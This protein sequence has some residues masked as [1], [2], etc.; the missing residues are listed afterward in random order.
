[1]A[2]PTNICCFLFCICLPIW[3]NQTPNTLQIHADIL[4]Q[5]GEGEA[6]DSGSIC[7][8]GTP[9]DCEWSAWKSNERNS[10]SQLIIAYP[11]LPGKVR[12]PRGFG[13]RTRDSAGN[14]AMGQLPDN[15]Q[16]GASRP[17]KLSAVPTLRCRR[18]R[19]GDEFILIWA[20]AVSRVMTAQDAVSIGN[21]ALLDSVHVQ[22][23]KV[24]AQTETLA[25][26]TGQTQCKHGTHATCHAPR[27]LM[28]AETQD[29]Q[30][31]HATHIQLTYL[32]LQ[33]THK[34]KVV[35]PKSQ[36]TLTKAS[37]RR[38]HTDELNRSSRSTCN[39]MHSQQPM[40]MHVH[41]HI[42]NT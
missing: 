19:D 20:H 25:Q 18:I 37:T 11:E 7:S 26:G 34:T 40:I 5:G 31:K 12:L 24:A 10:P 3:D 6:T 32:L 42:R 28:Y 9:R 8:P 30:C 36:H 22:A 35:L 23:S 13:F 38:V 1:M 29:M 14:Q 41:K 27:T 21:R 16:N 39:H 17:G 33:N 15:S 2:P 4:Q